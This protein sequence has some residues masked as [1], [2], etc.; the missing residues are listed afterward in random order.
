MEFEKYHALGN[1]YLVFDPKGKE[2][3][4]SEKKI[5]RICHRNFGL[6]SDGILLGPTNSDQA[7][8][9]LRILNPDGSEAE[10]SGNGLRIFARYLRDIKKVS[11]Q[12]FRVETLGGVVTC[13]VSE[14]KSVIIVEMGKVSFRSD[15]IPVNVTGE[16]REVCN[17]S[18]EVN[19]KS[20]QYYAATIGN[21]HCVVPV[22][23]SNPSL[24]IELGSSLEN[25]PNFPNR[26]NVQFL[27]IIDRNR[28]KIEIWE[29]GAGYTLASGSSSSAA[30]AV[31]RKMGACDEN[32]TVEMPGGEIELLIDDEFNVQMTGA[33]T[34]VAK[35]NLD[36]ECLQDH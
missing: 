13:Q 2:I 32:I 27:Q 15:V 28:I 8:F 18:I 6:G 7:D 11:T 24:A 20:L 31:A 25:H 22:E 26:T 14:D 12:P 29:R 33:A 23:E 5:I 30:G 19:G 36:L 34:H 4:F 17:E 3:S 35:M 10:K 16:A 1:D 9:K 21:P